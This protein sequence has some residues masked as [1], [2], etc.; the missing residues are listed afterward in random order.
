[1]TWINYRFAFEQFGILPEERL[2]IF[3]LVQPEPEVLSGVRVLGC[4]LN[5]FFEAGVGG[6]RQMNFKGTRRDGLSKISLYAIIV[7]LE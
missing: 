5:I 2:E 1:M 4:I 7:L 3:L 6:D